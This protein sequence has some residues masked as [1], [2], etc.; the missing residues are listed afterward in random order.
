[1]QKINF[2]NEET[3]DLSAETLNQLQ[4]NIETA[5]SEVLDQVYPIG[6][7][8]IDF[9]NTDFSN[10][11]G[12]T[13]ERELVGLTPI[14]IDETDTDYNQIGKTG[15][16]KAHK[17]AKEELPPTYIYPNEG[18]ND[19]ITG[20]YGP[21]PGAAYYSLKTGETNSN[22]PKLTANNPIMHTPL[23]HENR[24]PYKVVAYWKRT[25]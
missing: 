4:T 19:P 5:I 12:F 2:I 3:P 22:S 15:G 24:P 18:N 25:A 23:A 8:F 16:E 11:L 10:Y 21:T 20:G 1:M 17:L 13:W 9:T 14:G 7:G 6:R